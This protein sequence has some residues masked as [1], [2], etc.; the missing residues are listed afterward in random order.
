M[1]LIEACTL[2]PW[3]L[4]LV[5]SSASAG[6]I[7]HDTLHMVEFSMCLQQGEAWIQGP[8]ADLA[9]AGGPPHRPPCL[10]LGV[11][12][13]KV[14]HAGRQPALCA[15]AQ[16]RLSHCMRISTYTVLRELLQ[17]LAGSP[18]RA[19]CPPAATAGLQPRRRVGMS[20]LLTCTHSTMPF[21]N[22]MCLIQSSVPA[23]SECARELH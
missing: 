12:V 15:W 5:R 3:W 4:G 7:W 1:V 20:A 9:H 2:H 19:R 21:H 6:K 10:C 13:G 14:L 22:N 17:D 18:G 11:M 16:P 23:P 8:S